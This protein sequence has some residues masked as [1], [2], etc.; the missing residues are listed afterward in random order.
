MANIPSLLGLKF[1]LFCKAIFREF[2][3]ECAYRNLSESG[4]AL[5]LQFE[6]F[7]SRK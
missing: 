1:M 7:F 6:E 4:L 5:T 3:F 2:N